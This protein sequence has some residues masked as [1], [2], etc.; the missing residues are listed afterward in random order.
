MGCQ[1]VVG[2]PKC[3]QRG[4]QPDV[5]P[6]KEFKSNAYS[7]QQ[8]SFPYMLLA[9]PDARN[10]ALSGGSKLNARLRFGSQSPLVSELQTR[11]KGADFYEGVVDGTFGERTL[12][13]V[14]AFQGARFGPEA[15]DGIVG[16]VTAAA[17]GMDLPKF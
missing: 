11:L 7:L 14:L 3:P 4:N 8:E 6:W 16:P 2:Y 1:V 5:G 15:D 17:L 9:G 13:A 12:R 10:V